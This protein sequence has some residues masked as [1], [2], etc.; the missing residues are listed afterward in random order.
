MKR[1]STNASTAL[2]RILVFTAGA[3]LL[4]CRETPTQP[5]SGLTPR[6]LIAR[7]ELPSEP[8]VVISQL[9]GGGGNSGA[10]LKN[11]FIELFNPGSTPVSLAGWS[12]QYASAAG[13]SWQVTALTGTIAAGGYYLIQESAGTGGTASLPTPDAT[14]TIAMSATAGKVIVAQTTTAFVDACPAAGFVDV[15]SY[16]TGTNCG[17]TTA[18]LSNTLAALRGN[19]GCT[20]TGSPAA[21]FTAGPP[22]PRNSASGSNNCAVAAGP[23]ATV[24]IA[25]DSTGVT[26]GST[27]TFIATAKDA[28]GNVS[29][30]KFTWT[31]S[32]VSVATI[33]TNGIA[34]GVAGGLVTITATS[35]N[36]IAATAKLSVVAVGNVAGAIVISQIYGGG[37]NS[38]APLSNDYVELFNRSTQP[39]NVTGWSVQ[40]SSATGTFTQ[41]TPLSGT[42]PSGGYY[43]VQEAAGAATPA[44]LPTPD[45]IGVINM[46]ATS[47]KVLLAQTG[48]PL[49]TACPTGQIVVDIVSFGS[50]TGCG[51]P[52]PVLSNTTA[53]LRNSGGCAYTP[54]P[55][56][57]FSVG[58]P[59]PRN[60]AT[61]TRS[62]V[63]GPLDH[64]AITG[65][66]SVIAGS[67]TQLTGTAL[68][69][70]GNTVPGATFT[71]TS[72]D[73][74]IATVDATG[75]V[76]GVVASGNP[77][78]IT[79]TATAGAITKSA[80]VQF[81][82]NG[83]GINWIDIS[84]SSASFPAG[85]QTQLF[86][87]ARQQQGGTGIAATFTF[88][89]V[90]PQY[91]TV[92][93]VENTGIVTGVLAPTDGTL[94]GIKIT[95]TPT[96]GGA[97]YVFVAHP[98]TIEA[99]NPAPSSIYA[100]NDDFGD[101]TA[102]ST[103]NPLD[104][105][106]KRTQYTI[107]YN[108]SRGTPNWVSYEL[109]ARQIVAG[110]DRCNC[111]TADPTL[112]AAKQ[113]FTSDYTDG[114]F[115]R[116]HM[117]RS[118]DRTAGNVDNAIT[119]YLANVVPQTADL[120]EGVWA[121]F[122]D[123]LADS[124]A[125]GRAVYIITGPLFS[126]SHGLTFLKS[127]GK[128]AIPDST[129]KIALVGPANGGNPFNHTNVQNWSDLAGLSLLA[130]NM[131]NIAGVRNDPWQKY[132]TT[133]DAIEIATGYSF[134]SALPTGFRAALQY[135]DHAPVASFAVNGSAV[136]GSALTFDASASSDPDLGRTDLGGRTEALT[137]AWT[138]SD[139]TTATGK[140]VTKTF[141]SGGTFTA[142]LTVTD[143]FGW[144]VTTTANLTIETKMAEELATLDSATV[145]VN[146][147]AASDSILKLTQLAY[148]A[149]ISGAEQEIKAGHSAAA[150][151][152]LRG[153]IGE[154]DLTVDL[155]RMTSADAAALK[156]FVNE[157]IAELT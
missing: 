21:D 23:P 65:V 76:T 75:K 42:I 10:T 44:P 123:A 114:G 40:Y 20:Y 88:E 133:V 39:V 112:P 129:W 127:E 94:P 26:T 60:S 3:F 155:R 33:D 19:G 71:W 7:D 27:A 11:D 73:P 149:T 66:L 50:V 18:A 110:Q 47:G 157:V 64:V 103:G 54:D 74:T 90:N 120:N 116:G 51:N 147:L 62:C 139:G 96:A 4:S 29:S 43:L 150:I 63:A 68:D 15:V 154:I 131:P 14:G 92:A 45:I 105:L 113:I 67:T 1:T 101:P 117:T 12:V 37:G 141:T 78:T 34:T 77:V 138:F 140:V 128:V 17:T 13:S 32:N 55:S 41:A 125:A 151:L 156:V 144:P 28:G 58:A 69:A 100:I 36:G 6:A 134:L 106:I 79:A 148:N 122:E 137:Y 145:L 2:R 99:S 126:R 72:S 121:Q 35:A 115:D 143:V 57:D 87:T 30:T 9:Y 108:Q 152:L 102:A 56:V 93:T 59:A 22:T 24:T 136:Q 83:N 124:T 53:A 153:L 142:T 31:S 86:A 38:G 107:S 81:A 132:L 130:V 97:P 49:G 104:F 61:P 80:S 89:A 8:A 95:A 52:T 85:F 91:A 109:D 146:R 5:E 98:V 111:F 135:H 119:F 16:G 48:S 70:N 25:P 46:S 118:A 84:S 82:V